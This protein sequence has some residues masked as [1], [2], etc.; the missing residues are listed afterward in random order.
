MYKPRQRRDPGNRGLA[1]SLWMMSGLATAREDER[2]AAGP[3]PWEQGCGERGCDV[4]DAGGAWVECGVPSPMAWACRM[5]W[6][7]KPQPLSGCSAVACRSPCRVPGER[8]APAAA[9]GM[10]HYPQSMDHYGINKRKVVLQMRLSYRFTTRGEALRA[11]RDTDGSMSEQMGADSEAP[12]S[13]Q[14]VAACPLCPPWLCTYSSPS[15]T[16]SPSSCTH[17]S[18]SCTYSCPSC[19]HSLPVCIHSSHPTPSVRP[20]SKEGSFLPGPP[21]SLCGDQ[22][23]L[24]SSE[25]DPR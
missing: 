11:V 6:L 18:P 22:F 4:Q 24:H 21:R 19:T 5:P 7:L 23:G 14:A 1:L 15:C 20:P 9:Q 2:K 3:P 12:F 16:Y 13:R 25:G 10:Q 17:S 8:S